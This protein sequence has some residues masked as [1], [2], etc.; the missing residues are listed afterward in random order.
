[1]DI[2]E[3][4][5]NLTECHGVS[6]S[7]GSFSNYAEEILKKYCEKTYIDK[8]G[9]VIGYIPSGKEN[10]KKLMIEAHMD[11]IGLMVNRIDENGYIE[12]ETVGGVD[13]RVLPA[14]DVTVL[15]SEEIPGIIVSKP[16]HLRE[17]TDKDDALEIKDMLIDTGMSFEEL[18]KKVKTGDFIVICGKLVR[19]LNNCVSG[20]A[21]DNRAG[22]AAIIDFLEKLK[23]NNSEFDIYPVFTV[24]EE[25]GLIGA[26]SAAYNINPDVS[27]SIDVTFGKGENDENVAGTFD[28]GCG[29]V[30]FKGPDTSYEGTLNLIK[31]A[32]EKGIAYDIESG[33]SSGTNATAIQNVRGAKETYLLSIPLKYMHQT[34]EVLCLED[35]SKVSDLILEIASGGVCLA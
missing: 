10:S 34:V 6:G 28:L 35:I 19:L 12:F 17:N 8:A 9:N 31:R 7:L 32:E 4:L 11:R 15:G 21:L 33:S 23:E 13:K 25:T 14:A 29:A 22:M 2:F 24:G 30:I 27:V 26:Y 5:K 3:T 18:S 1:M 20:A 16:P